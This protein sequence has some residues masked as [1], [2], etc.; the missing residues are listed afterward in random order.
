MTA[1]LDVRDLAITYDTPRGIV[2]G[3]SGVDLSIGEGEIFGLVGESGSGKSTLCMS[4]LGF[5]PRAAHIERGEIRFDG[6]DLRHAGPDDWRAV[7]WRSIAYVPQGAMNVLNPV[8]RID[9]QF[10]DLIRDHLGQSLDGVWR[11]R[12][13]GV[14]R[15]VRLDPDVLSRYPH[16]L[17][18][19]MRQRI[20]IAMAILFEP[21]LIVADESTSALDVVSQ[22]V[23]LQTLSAV[24]DRIGASIILI[25]HD[26]ALQA[27]VADRVGIMLAGRLVEVGPVRSIFEA[28]RHPYTRLLI[29]SVPSIRQRAG[30][31]EV[32]TDDDR[33]R[34]EMSIGPL[35][36]VA[37]GH[38]V[39][40]AGEGG[41][42]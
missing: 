14:L 2:P 39:A 11:D 38:L 7:R 24:R 40:A 35:V 23:V 4:I 27:Q 19:G 22:R 32:A 8:R 13:A 18:G 20:C 10:A 26:L 30:I 28:P 33:R 25:G 34:W 3:V 5:L 37:P 9:S 42:S 6:R 16:E 12:L 1:M 41:P 36:E 15:S 29:A 21:R 31:A 17:S